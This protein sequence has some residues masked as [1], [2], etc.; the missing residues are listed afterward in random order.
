MTASTLWRFITSHQQ[1]AI[2][3]IAAHQRPPLHRP[4]VP[5]HEVVEHDGFQPGRRDRLGG[6][7]TDVAG[8]PD[9]QNGHGIRLSAG[10]RRGR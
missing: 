1:R 7:A 4:L 9:D 3:E 6:L 10:P 8:T 5:V 2:G